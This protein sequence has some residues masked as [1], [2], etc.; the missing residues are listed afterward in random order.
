[1]L[2]FGSILSSH[3]YARFLRMSSLYQVHADTNLVIEN[4]IYDNRMLAE[5]A[6]CCFSIFRPQSFQMQVTTSSRFRFG[7]T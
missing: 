4:F 5:R 3:F 1:M 2:T 7:T 6:F